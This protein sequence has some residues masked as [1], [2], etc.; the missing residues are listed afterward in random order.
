[1]IHFFMQYVGHSASPNI[2]AD[3]VPTC[4]RRYCEI[5]TIEPWA[6]QFIVI[7]SRQSVRRNDS[8]ASVEQL[9]ICGG[10]RGGQVL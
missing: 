2:Q 1:M 3:R 7:Q 9:N 10:R 4:P 8:N 6:I 5:A